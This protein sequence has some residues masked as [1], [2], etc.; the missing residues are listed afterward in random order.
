MG[1]LCLLAGGG[2]ARALDLN[3]N[4][5]SDVW[6]WQFGA[7]GLA[8]AADADVDGVDNAG[9][10]VAGTNP[11]DPGSVPRLFIQTTNLWWP[12][13]SGKLYRVEAA[14]NL[15]AGWATVASFAGTDAAFS[16]A[17]LM[18]TNGEYRR[19]RIESPDADG[20]GVS[21][22]EE[23]RMG[24][25][26]GRTNSG[27][28]DLADLPRMTAALTNTNSVVT[29]SL[30]DGLMYE[31]WPD[32]GVIALRRTGSLRPL[33]VNIA[34]GGSATRDV[35]YATA[36]GNT[37]SFPLGVAE[38]WA[39]FQPV[40]DANDGEGDETIVLNVLPGAGYTRSALTNAVVTLGNETAGSLPNPK[41]AARFLIQA[42]FGPDQDSTNDV[43]LIPENV[44]EVMAMGFEAWITNQLARPVGL[45]PALHRIRAHAAEFYTDSKSAAWWNRAMGV[46]NAGAG[47]AGP[48]AR[49]AAPAPGLCA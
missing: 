4:Q 9:E 28:Y 16:N 20:D 31:R 23:T 19:L 30:V 45:H 11:F 46:T 25:E 49:P 36:P 26:P 10:S 44:E 22:W 7:T 32:P 41:S 3:A 42:A 35:D 24:F 37:V 48:V 33:T 47:R 13:V 29:C 17:L 5:Q 39:E 6:E 12:T 1:V 21:D 15:L 38:V 14:T 27:R 2:V 8:A 34:L 40:A 18:T 43:D